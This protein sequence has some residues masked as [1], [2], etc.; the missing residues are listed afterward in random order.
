MV[1]HIPWQRDLGGARVQLELAEQLTTMGHQ[2][3]KFSW[4]DAYPSGTS[5]LLPGWLAGF[6]RRAER[7]V[8]QH[9]DSFDVIDAHQG[10]ILHT[11]TDLG[12]R[13]ALVVRSVG[14][15][16]FYREW[17][18]V[19]GTR[20]GGVRGALGWRRR[21]LVSLLNERAAEKS[22]DVADRVLVPNENEA[23][24]LSRRPEWACKV[25]TVPMAISTPAWNRLSQLP[26]RAPA[27]GQG[28]VLFLGAWGPR[29]GSRDWARIVREVW[30][31][32]PSTRF[33]F[34]GTGIAQE[35]VLT[36][37]GMSSDRR[38]EVIKSFTPGDLP[39]LL[40]RGSIGAFPSYVEGFGLA[41]LE[42]LAA[43]LPVVAYD[44]PGPRQLLA[45]LGSGLLTVPGDVDAFAGKL[46]DLLTEQPESY[47]LRALACREV[48]S[49]Y[50]WDAVAPLT[51]DL[52]RAAQEGVA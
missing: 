7:F 50:T 36:D 13:G 3:E 6:A 26:I 16:H 19:D 40:S 35:A 1:C 38:V 20:S 32:L 39:A 47:G 5:R 44:V 12:Q 42:K 14:L 29:K 18:R 28:T 17:E 33:L 45:P 10:N 41:V 27:P 8:R 51:L 24:F 52:Y 4:E 49:A 22:F 23:T 31:A 30:Q 46:V 2:V 15:V 37:L 48:A 34:A 25:Q 43:G 11:A 21:R 9:A